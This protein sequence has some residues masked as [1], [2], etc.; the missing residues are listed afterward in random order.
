MQWSTSAMATYA[1]LIHQ[2]QICASSIDKWDGSL[3]AKLCDFAEVIN[4][5]DVLVLVMIDH[6]LC[7]HFINWARW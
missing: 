5:A 7:K 2:Q 3:V 6:I 4:D 1:H